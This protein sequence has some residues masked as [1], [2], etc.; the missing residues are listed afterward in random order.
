MISYLLEKCKTMGMLNDE[1][2]F[3]E[4][5]YATNLMTRLD[6]IIGGISSDEAKLMRLFFNTYLDMRSLKLMY[7]ALLKQYESTWLLDSIGGFLG[8]FY[9]YMS[10]LNDLMKSEVISVVIISDMYDERYKEALE[11][12]SIYISRALRA[13]NI[14]K[15]YSFLALED[16]F[17][18]VNEVFADINGIGSNNGW[19]ATWQSN[20]TKFRLIMCVLVLSLSAVRR[21]N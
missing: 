16:G 6:G 5:R 21:S 11:K 17:E 19:L 4:R 18:K 8:Y 1:E 12:M 14:N 13:F 3:K 10:T 2:L 15:Y 20:V 7:T 9:D